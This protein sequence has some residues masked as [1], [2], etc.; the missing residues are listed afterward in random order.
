MKKLALIL[1]MVLILSLGLTAC[2]GGAK[3]PEAQT[4]SADKLKVVLLIPGTLGDKSFFDASNAGL[5][6]VKKDLGAETKVIEMGTDSTKWEPTFIDVSE[7]DWDIIISGN[8]TTELMNT[9]SVTY[10]D[11]RYINFD[12]SVAE[13][14]ANVYS[15]FY[16]TNQVSYLA[17]ALAGLVTKSDMELANK[18][19]VIG[20]LGGMDIPGINDF[21]VGYIEG[22]KNVNPEVKVI[23][24]YAGDFG[25]PAKG[26]EL[27]LVQYN[28][29][30]DIS[31][32]VAGGTGLGLIDAA[33][34]KSKYAIGVDSDQAML[35]KDS[36]PDKAVRIISSA[37]KRIDQAIFNA[38]KAHQE[39]TLQYGTHNEMGIAEGGVGLAKNE[40]YEKL[41]QNIKDQIEEIE[42][43]VSKGEIK[44]GTAFGVSSDKINELRESVK[45]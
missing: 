44:V 39:G 25:D 30:A 3:A 15:M 12:T 6:L 35:F 36:D 18:E 26:K 21:L 28:S 23:V 32:N 5:E 29:G 13:A 37:V 42:Q 40:Y 45:P 11:K 4:P 38:V 31:F 9:L 7:G 22:A 17:G 2:A 16:S 8:E 1:C 41:P 43:K 34:D 27:G 19:N 10:P 24:S 33:K 20:F 14:P